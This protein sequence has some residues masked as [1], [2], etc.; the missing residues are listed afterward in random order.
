MQQTNSNGQIPVELHDIIIPHLKGEQGLL[1][2]YGAVCRSWDNAVW[3]YRRLL[4]QRIYLTNDNISSFATLLR[5][6][7]R[8]IPCIRVVSAKCPLVTGKGGRMEVLDLSV[9]GTLPH[10]NELRLDELP[11]TPNLTTSISGL[12][13]RIRELEIGVLGVEDPFHFAQFVRLF[14]CLQRL[15]IKDRPKL[16]SSL[17]PNYA[18]LASHRQLDGMCKTSVIL[19]YNDAISS[20]PAS[21]PEACDQLPLKSLLE[22]VS[23]STETIRFGEQALCRSTECDCCDDEVGELWVTQELEPGKVQ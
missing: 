10:V 22:Y 18:Q 6:S 20:N 15:Y 8:I 14:T 11:I 16:V 13:D 21:Q 5:V 2:A 3:P 1:L 9:L 23:Q 7:P 12:A 4:F 19:L 17:T